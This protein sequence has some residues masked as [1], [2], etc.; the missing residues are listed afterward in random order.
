MGSEVNIAIFQYKRGSKNGGC[1]Q[2]ATPSVDVYVFNWCLEVKLHGQL[3]N[4]VARHCSAYAIEF[5]DAITQARIAAECA[6][7]D[8]QNVGGSRLTAIQVSLEVAP[9]HATVHIAELCMIEDVERFHAQL[10]AAFAFTT[11]TEV[12]EQ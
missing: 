10:Q 11:E 12:F 5:A 7:S 9:G 4:A 1:N 6:A 2:V 8:V 3:N